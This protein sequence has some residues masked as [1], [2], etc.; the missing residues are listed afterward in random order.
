M[1]QLEA[2][3]LLYYQIFSYLFCKINLF[4]HLTRHF[5]F[6]VVEVILNM[7]LFT[8]KMS[9]SYL[10][11]NTMYICIYLYIIICVTKYIWIY[12]LYTYIYIYSYI[13]YIMHRTMFVPNA[14]AIAHLELCIFT[15]YTHEY[16]YC[17]IWMVYDC[18]SFVRHFAVMIQRKKPLLLLPHIVYIHIYIY[19]QMWG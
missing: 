12:K 11:L 4:S 8:L 10:L 17:Y 18:S 15:I 16:I 9:L 19:T 6:D 5:Q 3:S 13:L 7:H 2:L 1:W 14:A